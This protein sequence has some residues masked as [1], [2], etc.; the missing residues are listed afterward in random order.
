VSSPLVP[1]ACSATVSMVVT[2]RVAPHSDDGRRRV[3]LRNVG[4]DKT[5]AY[6]PA[7]KL[8]VRTGQGSAPFSHWDLCS[9]RRVA[10]AMR[11]RARIVAS[12]RRNRRRAALHASLAQRANFCEGLGV[13][14]HAGL[15]LCALLPAYPGKSLAQVGFDAAG[16][17]KGSVQYRFHAAS[18]LWHGAPQPPPPTYMQDAFRRKLIMIIQ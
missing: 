17:A 11:R 16:V 9:A 3:R 10:G 2:V 14:L 7:R 1:D 13:R 4:A 18:C 8:S 12:A 5:R 15:L 6:D